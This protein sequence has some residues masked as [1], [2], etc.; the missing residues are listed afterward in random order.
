MQLSD[1]NIGIGDHLWPI[2]CKLTN[3]NKDNYDDIYYFSD[4]INYLYMK[5]IMSDS[6]DLRLLDYSKNL[7]DFTKHLEG[8]LLT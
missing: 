6:K 5:Y 3:F 4:D 7:N 8:K 2:N 1:L